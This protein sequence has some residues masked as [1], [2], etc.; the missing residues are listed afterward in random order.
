[1]ARS[2]RRSAI[3]GA[4]LGALDSSE[5]SVPAARAS[6]RTRTSYFAADASDSSS[7][8]GARRLPNRSRRAVG[9]AGGIGAERLS[10][11]VC[12]MPSFHPGRPDRPR[13]V[14]SAGAVLSL[15]TVRCWLAPAPAPEG[16]TS[17]CCSAS[18]F[19]ALDRG[20]RGAP[21]LLY[22]AAPFVPGRLLRQAASSP[23]AARW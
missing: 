22:P 10:H 17:P 12:R 20:A 14:A 18:L 4:Q 23:A 8:A 13:Q 6:T 15:P 3:L 9:A 7:A 1:M 2:R 19:A 21:H 5:P 11:G 16:P